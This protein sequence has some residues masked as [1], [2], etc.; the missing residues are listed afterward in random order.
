M[1]EPAF[2]PNWASPP[3]ETIAAILKARAISLHVFSQSVGLAERETVG[4]LNGKRPI[5]IT[6]ATRI[7]ASIGSTPR[8]W[9]QRE[10]RFQSSLKALDL[11]S[12]ETLFDACLNC[13]VKAWKNLRDWSAEDRLVTK[14]DHETR[15]GGG[16]LVPGDLNFCKE[17]EDAR[18]LALA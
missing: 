4:L 15:D 13:A 16:A 3:G 6:L 8:F 18:Q 11:H 9:I 12:R 5:D 17:S 7:S 2:Q 1:T 10:R 14:R